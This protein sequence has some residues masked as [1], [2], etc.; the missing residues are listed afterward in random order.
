MQIT[1][2]M[3]EAAAEAIWSTWCASEEGIAS[4]PFSTPL[5]WPELVVASETERFPLLRNLVA[6]SRLEA[7]NALR[8]GLSLL[9]IE[10]APEP[11]TA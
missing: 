9:V 1:A 7:E 4:T 10:S 6:L 11:F 8:A 2:A 3:I 5:K